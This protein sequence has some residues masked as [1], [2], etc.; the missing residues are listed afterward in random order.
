VRA[1]TSI[2]PNPTRV[3][4]QRAF[5]QSWRDSGLEVVSLNHPSELE[6]LKKAY[7]E[8]RFIATE[9]TGLATFGRH[10]VLINA[11]MDLIGQYGD[12]CMIVNADLRLE[13]VPGWWARLWQRADE[14]LPYLLQYNCKPDGTREI[15]PWGVSAFVVAPRLACRFVPSTLCMGMP[16]WDYWP[17]AVAVAAEQKLFAPHTVLAFHDTHPGNWTVDNW[18]R[19]AGEL[20]RVTSQTPILDH[21][22]DSASRLSRRMRSLIDQHTTVVDLG[23]AR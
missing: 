23:P 19:C 10:Y 2:A 12:S 9:R 22:M 5:L 3:A 18:L 17:T 8:V 20:D 21:I 7:P 16:W 15:E 1:L 6:W 4:A 13:V 11:F 14:G